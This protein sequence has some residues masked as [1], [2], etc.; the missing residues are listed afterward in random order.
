MGMKTIIG[1]LGFLTLSA[2]QAQPDPS[3]MKVPPGHSFRIFAHDIPNARLMQLTP[4]GDI[5][6]STY[7]KG[8]VVLVRADR[9]G[10]GKSDGTVPLLSGLNLPHGLWLEGA[11]LYVA[12]ETEVSVYDFDGSALTNRQIVLR[13]MPS[14]GGHVSR[15]V[16]R[17]P[18]GWLYVSIG[19]SCNVCIEAHEWRAAMVRVK[20]GR[21]PEIFARGLRNTVGFD[22]QPGTGALYGV[23]NG[24]DRLG[25]DIPDDELNLIVEGRHYGWPHAFN[26]NEPDPEFGGDMPKGFELTAPVHG[27]GAHVAPLSI[28]FLRDGRALVAQHGSWNRSEKAGYRVVALTWETDG[29]IR[30]EIFME[31]CLKGQTVLCRPVDVIEAS[32]GTIYVSDDRENAIYAIG[33]K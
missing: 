30:E 11:K 25:D 32:D 4:A 9:D 19:S 21:E 15:T 23:D 3:A 2:A 12:E 20:E 14:D 28:R 31:G 18:D 27:F 33:R 5:L 13:G 16:K 24:R 7:R 26:A 29:R 8:G 1:L 22:W 6:V 17:G 10:D